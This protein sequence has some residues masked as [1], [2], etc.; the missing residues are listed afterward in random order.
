MA[1][2]GSYPRAVLIFGSEWELSLALREQCL[3]LGLN[4]SYL[5]AVLI[6]GSEWELSEGSAY[7]WV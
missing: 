7:L 4:G 5:R 2:N 1:L 3:S 6:F